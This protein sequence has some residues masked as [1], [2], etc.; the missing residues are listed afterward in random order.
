MLK[1]LRKSKKIRYAIGLIFIGLYLAASRER[2]TTIATIFK[3]L[4]R[5]VTESIKTV[6]GGVVLAA[7]SAEVAGKVAETVVRKVDTAITDIHE[8]ATA[9]GSRGMSFVRAIVP[10]MESAASKTYGTL[11]D[12]LNEFP[13]YVVDAP[14]NNVRGFDYSKSYEHKENVLKEWIPLIQTIKRNLNTA[15]GQMPHRGDD[16]YRALYT[17]TVNKLTTQFADKLGAF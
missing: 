16:G 5:L 10:G 12:I 15:R 11:D 2:R 17:K 7:D 8:L 14:T 1:S 6:A 13:Q 4:D 9:G 3:R